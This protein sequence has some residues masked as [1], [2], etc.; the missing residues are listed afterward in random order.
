MF[1]RKIKTVDA[2]PWP[3]PQSEVDSDTEVTEVISAGQS[4]ACPECLVV[5]APSD[6]FCTACG[7][8]LPG[9]EIAPAPA[10]AGISPSTHFVQSPP[11]GG[12]STRHRRKAL[13]LGAGGLGV[14]AG[15]TGVVLLALAWHNERVDKHRAEATLRGALVSL[16]SNESKLSAA[17][18]VVGKQKAL[19]NE[20]A[21]VLRRVDPLLSNVDRL[22]Q[23]TSD[24]T[25]GR[26]TFSA[27]ANALVDSMITLG[28]DLIDAAN[29]S[30]VDVSYLSG[31]IDTVNSQI[32]TVRY[33]STNL[34]NYDDSYR[35]AS[36][37]FGNNADAF[38][39]SV[40]QLQGALR[41]L[42]GK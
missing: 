5:A 3:A 31:E 25:A 39:K 7:A 24:I 34:S 40:R 4:R 38:T 32:D 2:V 23:V 33:E 6:A 41:R 37:A 16:H 30:G 28:N 18:E 11:A 12:T 22:Q 29:I 20:T 36:N 21:A 17:K 27:D 19:L 14:A 42:A 10:R 35:A 9:L 1:K 26:D 15:L 13:A 8:E